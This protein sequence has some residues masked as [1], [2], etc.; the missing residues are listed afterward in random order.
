M[1]VFCV[2]DLVTLELQQ[3]SKHALYS[4]RQRVAFTSEASELQWQVVRL[5]PSDKSHPSGRDIP[6][7]C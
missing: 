2:S 5:H 1:F 6:S 3:T 7:D 4:I